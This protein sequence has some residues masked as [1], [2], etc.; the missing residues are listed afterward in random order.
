MAVFP[1]LLSFCLLLPKK[2]HDSF[3]N[4]IHHNFHPKSQGGWGNLLL[5]LLLP[6]FAVAGRICSSADVIDAVAACVLLL[7]FTGTTS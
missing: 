6:F 1:F 5:L 2:V 7:I 3:P 4:T